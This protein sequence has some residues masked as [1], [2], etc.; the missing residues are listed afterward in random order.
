MQFHSSICLG[1]LTI[2]FLGQP[3]FDMYPDLKIGLDMEDQKAQYS[4]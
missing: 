3:D 1:V 4:G 2:A